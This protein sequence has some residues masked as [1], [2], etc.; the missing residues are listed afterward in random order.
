MAWIEKRGSK[1]RVVWDNPTGEGDKRDRGREYFDTEDEAEIYLLKVKYEQKTHT[2]IKVT[3]MTVAEYFDYYMEIRGP[4]LEPMTRAGYWGQI[5][6]HIKP[7]LGKI[8]LK[9]L[10]PLHLEKFMAKQ[11]KE[12]RIEDLIRARANLE[13]KTDKQSLKAVARLTER[14]ATAEASGKAGLSPTTVN[15]QHKI[16]HKALKTAVKWM[17]IPLNVADNVEPPPRNPAKIDY[18]KKNVLQG[19]LNGIVDHSLYPII[20]TA[21]Y[22]GMRQGEILGLRDDDLDFENLEIKISRQLQYTK[23]TGFDPDKSCKQHSKGIIPMHPNLVFPLR[24]QLVQNDNRR[25]AYGEDWNSLRLVFCRWDGKPLDGGKV[26]KAFQDL[27]EEHGLPRLRFHALRHSCATM[28]RATGM[29]LADVQDILRHKQLNTTK[30]YYDHVEI[31]TLKKKY[32]K[33]VEYTQ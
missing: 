12:G 18:L 28:M 30:Q 6:K 20:I 33:F 7:N 24:R 32:Q 5:N 13:G 9:E 15:T 29:D 31:E 26:T 21:A 10:T 25:K 16:L 3:N 11:L 8:K 1:Y 27:L 4:K 14:I 19:F 23:E 2:F 17:L 22:S